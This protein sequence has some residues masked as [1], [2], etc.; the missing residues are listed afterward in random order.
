MPS[1][2][3]DERAFRADDRVDGVTRIWRGTTWINTNWFLVRGLRQHGF[4]D[5]A[6]GIRARSVELVNAHGFRESYNPLSG[7]PLGATEFGWST[8]VVDM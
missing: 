5:L 8:L 2:A 3:R 4:T 7:E 6:D 1:V